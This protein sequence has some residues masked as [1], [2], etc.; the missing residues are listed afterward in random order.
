M[1]NDN[2]VVALVESES[3]SDFDSVR[4]TYQQIIDVTA[5]TPA[6]KVGWSFENG[7]ILRKF[8]NL[9]ARQLRLGLVGIGLDLTTIDTAIDGLPEPTRSYAKISWEYSVEFE[10]QNAL[11]V[12]VASMLGWT[13]EN[14]DMLWEIGS[15]L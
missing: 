14:L 2:L 13:D 4:H 8:K 9:S 6:P 7:V 1:I 12:T 15:A 10:R 5:Q 11:V 3:D